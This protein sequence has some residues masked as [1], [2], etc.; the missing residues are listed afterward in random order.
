MTR[1]LVL[2]LVMVFAWPV[3]A[4]HVAL[5]LGNA[6][7]RHIA[8][9]ENASRDAR[10]MAAA[11][12]ELG[13]RVFEGIDLPRRETLELIREF[14]NALGPEDL[15]LFYYAGHGVQIGSS[16]YLLPVDAA[17]GTR[18]ELI[19]AGIRIQA[20]LKTME[21]RARTRIVIL[22]ACRN[23]PFLRDDEGRS[24][25]ATRGLLRMEAGVG[26]FIAFSTEPG[27]V[28][29]DGE[30]RNSPFTSALLRKIRSPGAD[31]HEVMRAVRID[32]LDA[33]GGA[34]VPWENS[35][36]IDRVFLTPGAEEDAREPPQD[37]FAK[38]HFVGG[39]EPGDG[40]FLALRDAPSR[41]ANLIARM[42]P[43][44]RLRV[45][46]QT[47]TWWRVE[48][49]FGDRGWAHSRWIRCCADGA[50][51]EDA[52]VTHLPRSKLVG[53]EICR[54]FL[55]SG[56][57]AGTICAASELAAQGSN[58]YHGDN[59]FDGRLDTGWTEAA[60]EHGIGEYVA[61]DFDRPHAFG[62]LL[63]VNGYA[64]S[65]QSFSRNARVRGL[66][67]TASNGR[68]FIATLS[69]N[70][71]WQALDVS[72]FGEV[73]W[74]RLEIASVYPGSRWKDT[75]ISELALQ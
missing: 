22:D 57:Y 31:V 21:N 67:V 75:V 64:K 47:G 9:L 30:G 33:T 66:K 60:D 38:G 56:A 65:P 41:E 26:S 55:I 61:L 39:L 6:G 17:P 37:P 19:E 59:L 62:T 72:G 13:Y 35:A 68:T 73:S 2:A 5:V 40:G 69:D 18:P 63:L 32:V 15:A 8:A 25:G 70:A 12:R 20:V 53:R 3:R 42:G 48:T 52:P 34:Q 46:E 16:N 51:P 7:Y 11:L 74:L 14:G 49:E 45:L 27:N 29:L 50:A 43:E 71:G 4:E 24:L 1:F 28:A 58:T 10:D 36:L 23:N 54:R 44:T